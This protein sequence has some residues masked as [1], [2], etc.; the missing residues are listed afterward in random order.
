MSGMIDERNLEDEQSWHPIMRY[1][2]S[3]VLLNGVMGAE[4]PSRGVALE[5]L[6]VN[7]ALRRYYEKKTA[8]RSVGISSSVE[9]HDRQPEH[10]S[11]IKFAQPSGSLGVQ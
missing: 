11:C 1:V 2:E 9:R 3:Q 6:P 5:Q 4:E 8:I 10:A 7:T